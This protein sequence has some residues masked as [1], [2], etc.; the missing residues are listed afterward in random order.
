MKGGI[1]KPAY[2]MGLGILFLSMGI[3]LS[4]GDIHPAAG[5]ATTAFGLIYVLQ[6]VRMKRN[7]EDA[8]RGDERTRRIGAWA[9]SYSWFLT[10][11]ALSALFWLIH[12]KAVALGPEDVA[13]SMMLLM[14]FS[15]LFFRWMLSRKGDVA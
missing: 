10:L 13:A 15:L 12:L 6:S 7:G 5:A 4:F 11:L 2:M 14:V 1:D 3:G 8:L 9:A